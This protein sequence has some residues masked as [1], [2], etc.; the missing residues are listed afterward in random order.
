MGDFYPQTVKEFA[1]IIGFE[2]NTKFSIK[3]TNKE[4]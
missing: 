3:Y 4:N 1:E 2:F